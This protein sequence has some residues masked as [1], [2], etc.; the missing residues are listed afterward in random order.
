MLSSPPA[1]HVDDPDSEPGPFTDHGSY[2]RARGIKPPEAFRISAPVPAASG[3]ASWLVI[4]SYTRDRDRDPGQLAAI[5]GDPAG[6]G[7]RVL[8][9]QSLEHTDATVIRAA[10]PLPPRYRLSLRVGYADFGD[11]VAG[12]SN[13]YD[14]DER[15]EPWGDTSAV[16]ENGFYWL[17][18]LDTIPRPHNNIWIHHH[19]KVVV[20]SDNHFPPWAEIWDGQRFVASGERPVM[21]M[22]IAG[23]GETHPKNG[24]PFRSF[25][26]GAVQPMGAIRAVDAYLPETWY[27]VTIERDPTRYQIAVSGRFRHG[28]D[29]TYRATFD[30]AELCV[31]HYNQPGESLHPECADSAPLPESGSTAPAWPLTPGYPDYFMFGDPHVNYYEGAVYYDDIVLQVP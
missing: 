13:G 12:G 9:V 24:N 27:R 31:W 21:I 8:R 15:A 16:G 22:A 3:A 5:V 4:E 30:S 1:W 10:S 2:F 19:R 14:G 20:D 18:I 23:N 26:A 29:R 11:G 17:T 25:S 7:N 6:G 28:G